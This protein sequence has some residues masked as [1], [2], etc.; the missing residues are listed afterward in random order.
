ME[1]V[2]ETLHNELTYLSMV[3]NLLENNVES[4]FG[5]SDCKAC[6]GVQAGFDLGKSFPSLVSRDVD[7]A[8]AMAGANDILKTNKKALTLLMA[9][10]KAGPDG[11]HATTLIKHPQVNGLQI[12]IRDNFLDVNVQLAGADV[13]N[14]V[15]SLMSTL[16]ILTLVFAAHNNCQPQHLS[17]QFSSIWVASDQVSGA[18]VMLNTE[19]S[20]PAVMSL[21]T[22][23]ATTLKPIS[24]RDITMTSWADYGG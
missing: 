22:E 20:P 13:L 14:D 7:I 11:S 21:R 10:C 3:N 19:I 18:K 23:A 2:H 16:G 15:P 1:N 5:G 8:V 12:L 6:L 4:V 9:Q 17:M 24:L